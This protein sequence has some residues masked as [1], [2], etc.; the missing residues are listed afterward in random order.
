MV[1]NLMFERLSH[2]LWEELMGLS[3]IILILKDIYKFRHFT[4]EK[5]F[6]VPKDHFLF[7][8]SRIHSSFNSAYLLFL[9]LAHLKTNE[10]FTIGVVI[11]KQIR[12]LF[13]FSIHSANNQSFFQNFEIL[14]LNALI[15]SHCNQFLNIFESFS[16][17]SSHFKTEN[18]FLS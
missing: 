5:H 7:D 16:F 6:V 2:Q 18:N 4:A 15:K 17:M 9:E 14:F 3:S 11:I 12:S 8:D 13:Q 1:N 10:A